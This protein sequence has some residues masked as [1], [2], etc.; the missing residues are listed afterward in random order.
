MLFPSCHT[1]SYNFFNSV[2]H[3]VRIS[4]KL[5]HYDP[6]SFLPNPFLLTTTNLVF[7]DD[8]IFAD[9]DF[10][11]G[12]FDFFFADFAFL[13][14]SQTLL[15][16]PTRRLSLPISSPSSFIFTDSTSSMPPSFNVMPTL[17]HCFLC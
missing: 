11:F 6:N 1:R 5:E 16:T 7:H 14:N 2:L 13:T 10:L 8:F 17:L 3:D 4:Q 15:S 12:N 9:F